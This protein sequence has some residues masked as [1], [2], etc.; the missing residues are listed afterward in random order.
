MLIYDIPLIPGPTSVPESVRRA[1]L[2]D[3]ASSDVEPEYSQLYADV[4]D[5]LRIILGTENQMA[6][7]TGE[8]MIAL[9]GAL[10]SCI[11]PGE[12][13]LAVSTGVFGYGIGEMAAAIGAEVQWVEFGFD[14]ILRPE[15]V[16]DAIKTFRPKMVTAVHCETPSGTLNPVDLVGELVRQYEVPLYYVDA[17]AS[18][19]GVPVLTDAWAIDLCLIGTQKALSALPDLA[20]VAVSDRAWEIIADVNYPGYDALAPYKEALEKRW[21]PYTPA[22]ASLAGLHKACRLVLDE[23]LEKVYARHVQ[24]A[25]AC[26]D[27]AREI[28]LS[29]YPVAEA[30]CSPT[31][32]AL[33][34]PASTSWDDLDRRLREQGVGIGG[35]L[36]PLA[37]KVMRIG[38]M[39]IQA[40]MTLVERG[41]D[42]LAQVLAEGES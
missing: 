26:R 41:M 12:R 35:S 20:A 6:I 31:V 1:Y 15:P 25:Q 28:G 4:Q 3:Y 14:E 24:V 7:M 39:G 16:A 42:L 22:W 9:W 23:G 10:K 5:Q 2:T 17:V 11:R 27:R 34:V 29:L 36:G 19:A 38:H 18:A 21:F 40:N 33:Q 8:G 13:V 30:G 32:T 37:G